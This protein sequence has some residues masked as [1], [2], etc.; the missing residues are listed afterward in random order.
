RTALSNGPL[1]ENNGQP[2][3]EEAGRD[4]TVEEV[5]RSVVDVD[6]KDGSRKP[7]NGAPRRPT[8]SS[9]STDLGTA[10]IQFGLSNQ[11]KPVTI[12]TL[13]PSCA[14]FVIRALDAA[15]AKTTV[16]FGKVDPP[17]WPANTPSPVD[18]VW[19]TLVQTYYPAPG[20]AS[21][22]NSVPPGDVLQFREVGT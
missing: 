14:N 4:L 13:Y 18:Y 22:L 20:T 19:G 17:G 3:E 5:E 11:G 21:A 8:T 7:L 6:F 2:P 15:G 16:D 9:A 12:G 1:L 10:A